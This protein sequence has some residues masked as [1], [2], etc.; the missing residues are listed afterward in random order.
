M[1]KKC[2]FAAIALACAALLAGECQ[3]LEGG[4][5]RPVSGALITPYI[6]LVPPLPGPA[7]TIGEIYYTGT[8]AGGASTPIAGN[9]ALGIEANVS[10][11]P[12]TLSYIWNTPGTPKWNFASALN[13]PITYLDLS[14]NLS[15]GNRTVRVFDRN[16]GLFD[17]AIVPLVAS[18]HLSKTDHLAFSFTVWVP[19]G[20][21]VKGKL[22]NLGLNTWTLIPGVA[23]TKIFP[24]ANVE[25]MCCKPPAECNE[26]AQAE[27]L[28]ENV[29]LL[30]A[31]P[32][33]TG[34]F[35]S[36]FDDATPHRFPHSGLVNGSRSKAAWVSSCL[37]TRWAGWRKWSSIAT[38]S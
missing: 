37:S 25:V 24:E 6:G 9:V 18:W 3:A 14:A 13:L 10:F 31:K 34:V 16:F 29:A 19:S 28:Q 21:Y 36:Q 32:S 8:I 15:I 7:V 33:V 38:S 26:V 22:A 5:G 27:W 35:L 23:Y 1:A 17:I 4:I 12:V 11:T 2:V 20:S 30:L